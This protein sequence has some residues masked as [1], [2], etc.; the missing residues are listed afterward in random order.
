MVNNP[1]S[2]EDIK[3]LQENLS[4]I[5]NAAGWTAAELAD[6]IG[7]TK[8]TISNLENQKTKMSKTQYLA[9]QTVI[10]LKI[11]EEKQNLNNKES[12]KLELLMDKIVMKYPKQENA[13]NPNLS[14]DTPTEQTDNSSATLD[15]VAAGAAVGATA[16]AIVATAGLAS[17]SPVVLGATLMPWIC[18]MFG[19]DKNNK[20]NKK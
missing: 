7:V 14:E 2:A 13:E 3:N 8:Q 15:K 20:D 18:R 12:S 4:L 10:S 19:D 5:R 6:L 9:L 17:I 16:G 11:I 1:E